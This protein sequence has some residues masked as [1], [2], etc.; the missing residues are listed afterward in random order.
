M[1]LRV[2]TK[3]GGRRAP[4]N[5]VARTRLRLLRQAGFDSVGLR[6]TPGGSSCGRVSADGKL[7]GTRGDVCHSGSTA[8]GYDCPR[9][10]RSGVQPT[11]AEKSRQ[12]MV[13]PFACCSCACDRPAGNM[14]REPSASCQV[15]NVSF[16]NNSHGTDYP[17][18]D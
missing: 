8:I 7:R 10:D 5:G 3:A 15:S 9:C 14:A 11:E 4:F 16:T 18:R 6:P 1:S 17:G 2:Q 12:Q 13:R